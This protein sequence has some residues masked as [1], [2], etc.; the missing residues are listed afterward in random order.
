MIGAISFSNNMDNSWSEAICVVS[1]RYHWTDQGLSNFIASVLVH[2]TFS[3][4]SKNEGGQDCYIM[5]PNDVKHQIN[6]RQSM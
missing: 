3:H 4:H 5:Q 1:T 2:K 6:L